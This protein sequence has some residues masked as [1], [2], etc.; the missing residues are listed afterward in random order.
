MKLRRYGRFLWMP[1]AFLLGALFLSTLPFSVLT[2]IGAPDRVFRIVLFL[3]VLLGG[4]LGA[5]MALGA[6]LARAKVLSKSGG[7]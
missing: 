6:A 5:I 7:P 3:T 4:L 2:A 1:A